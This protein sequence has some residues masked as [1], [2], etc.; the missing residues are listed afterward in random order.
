MNHK[1]NEKLSTPAVGEAS[2]STLMLDTLLETIEAPTVDEP[3]VILSASEQ[4]MNF[5]IYIRFTVRADGP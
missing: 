1:R 3:H 4:I 2:A 5:F